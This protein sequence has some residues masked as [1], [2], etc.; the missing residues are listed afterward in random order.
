MLTNIFFMCPLSE[1]Y[2]LKLSYYRIS[3]I[4]IDILI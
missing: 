4:E 3:M 2:K 1:S